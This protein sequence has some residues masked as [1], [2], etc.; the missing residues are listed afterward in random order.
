MSCDAVSGDLINL[1][2][3][4]TANSIILTF[5]IFDFG[6]KYEESKSLGGAETRLKSEIEERNTTPSIGKID[7]K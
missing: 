4:L 3:S 6:R 1:M 5:V 2:L 7:L